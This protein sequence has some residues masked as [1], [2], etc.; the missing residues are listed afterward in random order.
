MA[1]SKL[2]WGLF[3]GSKGKDSSGGSGGTSEGGGGKVKTKDCRV[4]GGTGA[5]ACEVCG[6][7]GIDKKG[8]TC[9]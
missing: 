2:W 6:G 5:I 1:D 4:C 7:S 8:G 9:L 3:G